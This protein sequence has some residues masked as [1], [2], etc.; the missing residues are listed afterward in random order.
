MSNKGESHMELT[1]I[2]SIAITSPGIIEVRWS[3]VTVRG[4][5][6]R[7][8][9]NHRTALDVDTDIDAQLAAVSA[10][11]ETMGFPAVAEADADI[12]REMSQVG[13]THPVI[14]TNRNNRLEEKAVALEAQLTEIGKMAEAAI[15][16]AATEAEAKVR[17][18]AAEGETEKVIAKRSAE[19]VEVART[20][21]EAAFAEQTAPYTAEIKRLRRLKTAR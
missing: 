2:G 20:E 18:E 13:A 21:T 4:N 10:H 6:K 11:L 14:G 3:L 15:D 8:S 1:E 12:I 9:E 16:L 7:I 17:S 19:A 5:G